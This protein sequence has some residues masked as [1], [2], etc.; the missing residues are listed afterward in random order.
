[1]QIVD[2][3]IQKRV[4]MFVHG[5][6]KAN[7]QHAQKTSVLGFSWKSIT[8]PEHEDKETVLGSNITWT[9][10]KFCNKSHLDN[11]SIPTAYFLSAPTFSEDGRLATL[12]DKYDMTG[13]EFLL[14]SLKYLVDPNR[15][16]GIVE[17]L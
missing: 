8:R 7:D 1:M 17:M 14:P 15:H 6:L 11:D 10:F 5:W 13:G 9:H 4:T 12:E 3:F 16:D 2:H